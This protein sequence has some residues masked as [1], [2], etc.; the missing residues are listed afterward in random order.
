MA[1]GSRLYHQSPN[2]HFSSAPTITAD[3]PTT[4]NNAD[5]G[6]VL[7]LFSQTCP[8]DH[9]Q[10][11]ENGNE[12]YKLPHSAFIAKNSMGSLEVLPGAA[13]CCVAAGNLYI[14]P[15]PGTPIPAACTG[16]GTMVFPAVLKFQ[17]LYWMD[18]TNACAPKPANETCSALG[19]PECIQESCFQCADGKDCYCVPWGICNTASAPAMAC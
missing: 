4:T 1:D 2:N 17:L 19:G 15:P 14:N 6:C 13:A 10:R 11:F 12:F 16:T 7:I 3:S 5:S 18:Y 8:T 9:P